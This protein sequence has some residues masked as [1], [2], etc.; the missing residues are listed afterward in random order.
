MQTRFKRWRQLLLVA[1]S[2]PAIPYGGQAAIEG[3]MMKGTTHAALAI[4]REDGEIEVLDREVTTRFPKLTRLPLLRGFFI[5]WDMMTLGMWALRESSHRYEVDL[6]AKEAVAKG[7][8]AP[9]R[10]ASAEKSGLA[11]NIMIGVSF[12]IALLVFKVLPAAI[13]TGVFTLAGAGGDTSVMEAIKHGPLGGVENAGFGMQFAAN[14]IEGL[15][16]LCIFVG[17]VTLVG[18]I[19]EIA[20]VFQYH[21]AEHIVI[22]AYED[23]PERVQDVSF[24]QEHS[25]A[26]P[27]CGTSFIVIL[28]LM[29]I[30]LYTALD[31]ALVSWVPA[32]VAEGGNLP[33]WWVRWPLRH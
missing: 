14:L 3:V 7:E 10:S 2:A 15:V 27:R 29:G 19:K 30:V 18:R 5:L 28:I 26:H 16:K 21:G 11:Q 24:I 31:W 1:L 9:E 13:A 25:V 32:V 23:E 33:V 22:N 17:Y 12:V 6:E 8:A 20:R 4:R